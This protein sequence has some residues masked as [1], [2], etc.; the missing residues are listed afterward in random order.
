MRRTG[1]MSAVIALLACCAHHADAAQSTCDPDLARVEADSGAGFHS[2]YFFY[3]PAGLK[4]G[5]ATIL[6][7]PNNTG[8][9]TDDLAVHESSACRFAAERKV[10]AQSLARSCL[11]RP[12]RGLALAGTS[13]HT[14][15]IGMRSSQISPL[16]SALTCSLSR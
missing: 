10:I 8:H 6:V 13:I 4:S 1:C 15:W 9:S 11:S 7:L 12:F 2:P 5:S 14:R 3:T 16:S